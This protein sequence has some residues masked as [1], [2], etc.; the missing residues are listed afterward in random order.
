M[1][2]PYG[3]AFEAEPAVAWPDQLGTPAQFIDPSL[4]SPD[5]QFA[6]LVDMLEVDDALNPAPYEA[7]PPWGESTELDEY[8]PE[9]VL[10]ESY[11]PAPDLQ[12]AAAA[13]LISVIS[14]AF[15]YDIPERLWENDDQYHGLGVP[16][17]VENVDQPYESGHTQ[18]NVIDPSAEHGWDAWTGRPQLA[19]VARMENHFW[20]YSAGVHRRFGDYP[21]EKLEM[22]YVLQTQQFRDLLLAEIKARGQHGM[23]VKQVPSLPYTEEVL[24]IDPSVLTPEPDIGP[25]G[26]LP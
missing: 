17:G 2:L 20:G 18:I 23:I 10:E 26:V 3:A 1:S 7:S 24:A 6:Y 16:P 13:D 22:P 12:S 11:E 14:D 8:L 9:S 21:V 15:T 5:N 25:E 19:R 4:E